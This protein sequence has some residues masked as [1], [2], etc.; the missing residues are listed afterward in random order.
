MGDD[1]KRGNLRRVGTDGGG[2]D[3]PAVPLAEPKPVWKRPTVRM[4]NIEGTASGQFLD[5]YI[6]V[7]NLGYTPAQS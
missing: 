6:V 2:V 4:M 5:S 1:A 3:R 7:E